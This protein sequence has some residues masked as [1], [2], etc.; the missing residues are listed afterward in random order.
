M[1]ECARATHGTHTTIHSASIKLQ[2]SINVLSHTLTSRVQNSKQR[3]NCPLQC[4]HE[5]L[6]LPSVC[7]CVCVCVCACA[8]MSACLCQCQCVRVPDVIVHRVV[9]GL[10]VCVC[11][12]TQAL[13]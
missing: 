7:V 13:V 12:C 5:M 10:C 9:K 3:Q 6:S 11:V 4:T 1:Y 8:R 2:G